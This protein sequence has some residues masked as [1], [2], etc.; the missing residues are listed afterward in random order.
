MIG[1]DRQ[2][3]M[4]RLDEAVR[5]QHAVLDRFGEQSA[6]FTS[7]GHVVAAWRREELRTR[8]PKSKAD[9]FWEKHGFEW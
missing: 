7:I 6:A 1:S 9:E 4:K 8:P 5:M 2:T 3:I